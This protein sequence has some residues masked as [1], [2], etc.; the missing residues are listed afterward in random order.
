MSALQDVNFPDKW[1]ADYRR[2]TDGWDLRGPTR[3]FKRL[4]AG[5]LPPGRMLVPGAGRGHDAREFA[6]HG[7]QVTAVD[8]SPFVVRE[9]HRLAAPDAPVEI[10][11]QDVFVLPPELDGAFDYVL[12]YTCFC[13]IDPRRRGEYADRVA[14]WLKPGGVYLQ[15]AFPL[16]DHAGG[17]PFAV[18]V[19]EILDLFGARGFT[20]VT[21]EIPAESPPVRR[22]LEELFIF[23]RGETMP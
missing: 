4:A 16:A 17:P 14:R 1:E 22:G 7:F 13:A 3:I 6:R 18:S 2:G 11:E 5:G 12:D 8:F 9:M 15:L 10:L 19:S 21:R 20:L 23:K